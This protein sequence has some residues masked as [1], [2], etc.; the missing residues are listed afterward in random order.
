MCQIAEKKKRKVMCE[1]RFTL[2]LDMCSDLT[3]FVLTLTFFKTYYKG[4]FY[5]VIVDVLP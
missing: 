4:M 3:D 2:N 1:S 5:Y